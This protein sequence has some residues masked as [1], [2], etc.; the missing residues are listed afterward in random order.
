MKLF[1]IACQSIRF[2]WNRRWSTICFAVA[3]E[4]KPTVDLSLCDLIK[5][6]I[7]TNELLW[8]A[9]SLHNLTFERMLYPHPLTFCCNSK[10][11]SKRIY[12]KRKL[13][14]FGISMLLIVAMLLISSVNFLLYLKHIV[15]LPFSL[16]NGIYAGIC[17]NVLFIN[18][19]YV[20]KP[21]DH[22]VESIN[23]LFKEHIRNQQYSK[24]WNIL[25]NPCTKQSNF[26]KQ[27]RV[28]LKLRSFPE[29]GMLFNRVWHSLSLKLHV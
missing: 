13:I 5:L 4:A 22:F 15:S 1:L 26:L 2:K 29:T 3:I 14:P 17:W 6:V 10:E 23:A 19:V 8:N 24:F 28:S 12:P 20:A 27:K 9:Y 18:M 11:F 7:M 16:L 25:R 21:G